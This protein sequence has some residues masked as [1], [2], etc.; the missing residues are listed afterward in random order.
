[1]EDNRDITFDKL[2]ELAKKNKKIIF[3]CNDMDIF[4]L[5]ISKK[6]ILNEL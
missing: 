1:M 6:D 4:L 2:V 5:E 3:L